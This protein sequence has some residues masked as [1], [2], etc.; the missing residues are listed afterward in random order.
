MDTLYHTIR[1][2]VD[3]PGVTLVYRKGFNAE[4]IGQDELNSRP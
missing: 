4:Q 2:K 1:V 3:R